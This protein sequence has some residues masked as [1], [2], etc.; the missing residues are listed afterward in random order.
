[1]GQ[2]YH[3]GQRRRQDD[4]D[5]RRLADRLDVATTDRIGDAH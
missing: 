2:H 1:M 5:T 3:E 4:F